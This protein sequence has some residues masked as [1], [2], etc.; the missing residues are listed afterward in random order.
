MKA[1]PARQLQ[2]VIDLERY[3]P[4]YLT[5]I[6][7]KLTRGASQAYLAAFDTGVESWRLLVLL[8]I[9]TSISAQRCSK[10]IGMDKASVSRAF[11]SMQSRGLITIG[12]DAE[13]GRVRIATI[14]AKGRRLHDSIMAVALER[15][16]ALL[17]VFNEKEQD[18]LIGLLRRMHE[19][20]PAVETATE[21]Y[22]ATHFPKLRLK[23]AARRDDE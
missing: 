13:D 9:E 1:A 19:N 6:A 3:V 12:L 22:L 7:N 15:E 18:V 11:K 5:W 21:R 16:R 20:L 23:A 14:T 17:S 8:A 2:P 4:G 10:V